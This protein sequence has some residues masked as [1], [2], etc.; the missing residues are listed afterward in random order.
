MKIIAELATALDLVR[1]RAA[2]VLDADELG[3][4]D[5]IAERVEERR[6]FP[7]DTLVVAL[8]GGTGAGK[9][10]LLNALAGEEVASVSAVRPHTDQALA[11]TPADPSFELTAFLDDMGISERFGQGRFSDLAVI[12]LPD[13]DSIATAHRELVWDLLPEV[14]AIIWV[15]DPDK[16]RDVEFL[17]DYVGGL[18]AYQDQA[19]FVLNKADLLSDTAVEEVTAD[20]IGQLEVHGIV[21]PKVFALAA[22]PPHQDPIGTEELARHLEEQME[23]KR[24]F[25][26][27][28]V[29]DV[30]RAV[31]MMLTRARLDS[32]GAVSF[33]ERWEAASTEI[34]AALDAEDPEG[35]TTVMDDFIASL[36]AMVGSSFGRRLVDAVPPHLIE[37]ELSAAAAAAAPV[38]PSTKAMRRRSKNRIEPD[39]E[40][41]PAPDLDASL[42]QPLR[43]LLWNRSYLGATLAAV[44]VQAAQAQARLTG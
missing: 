34:G 24:V 43:A 19:L 39:V 42:G 31:S 22:A 5:D 23:A 4:I 30:G 13:Q 35:A 37:R 11:L 12:D 10:S 16:Y 9:S 40:R 8:A 38:P 28:T 17:R 27:K 3:D 6:G 26:S 29:A 2:D 36:V 18:A 25:A 21:E 41:P 20:F 44:S 1:L 7:G 15:A 14:D 33:D 32:G